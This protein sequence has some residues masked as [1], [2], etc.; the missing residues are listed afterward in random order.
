MSTHCKHFFLEIR[1]KRS[2]PNLVLKDILANGNRG[3]REIGKRWGVAHPHESLWPDASSERGR[4][5]IITFDIERQQNVFV[6]YILSE[7]MLLF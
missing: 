6:R 3:K 7:L 1:K 5:K 2:G 4:Q